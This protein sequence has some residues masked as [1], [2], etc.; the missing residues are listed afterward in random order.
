M[1]AG[2][3]DVIKKRIIQ[4]HRYTYLNQKHH[5]WETLSFA[6]LCFLATI[7][8]SSYFCVWDSHIKS[9]I[10]GCSLNTVFNVV[11]VRFQQQ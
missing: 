10:Q 1:S 9:S 11:P 8:S 6:W 2:N 7:C 4:T 3:T 5:S